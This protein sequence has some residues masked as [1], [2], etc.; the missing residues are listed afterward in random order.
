MVISTDAERE[1]QNKSI[2]SETRELLQSDKDQLQ[3]P[4]AN[5]K[6]HDKM[7]DS[8]L[9]YKQK[10]LFYFHSTCS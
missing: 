9:Y 6:L 5:I 3:K 7:N 1:K 10:C 2:N 4:T 8:L